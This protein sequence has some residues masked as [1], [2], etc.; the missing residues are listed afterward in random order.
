MC[1]DLLH[2]GATMMNVLLQFKML[3]CFGCLSGLLSV[4][5][6]AVCLV[7]LM[8]IL[9]VNTCELWL[10]GGTLCGIF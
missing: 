8:T 3:G 9:D 2:E 4:V 6:A 10:I 1:R 5:I 7:I